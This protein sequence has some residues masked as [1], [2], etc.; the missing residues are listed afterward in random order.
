LNRTHLFYII[1]AIAIVG[2]LIAIGYSLSQVQ[3]NQPVPINNTKP[4]PVPIVC[5][6][7]TYLHNGTCVAEP[8][9]ICDQG[10]MF[11]TTSELCEPVPTIPPEEP[12]QPLDLI[13]VGDIH[14]SKG[15]EVGA[16]IQA[17]NPD[18]IA[19]LGDLCYTDN[20]D[21]IEEFYGQN[22]SRI[23]CVIGN[24]EKPIIKI[25]LELCG[26][27]YHIKQFNNVLLFG[28]NTETPLTTETKL[29]TALL[30]NSTFMKDIKTVFIFTHKGVATP[31]QSHHPASEDSDVPKF[32]QAVIKDAPKN[33]TL[34]FVNGHNH[35]RSEGKI[36]TNYFIQSGGGGRSTSGYECGINAQFYYCEQDYGFVKFRLMPTGDVTWHFYNA[37][38][39]EVR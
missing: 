1:A 17:Q 36:G 7:G 10:E 31:P 25:A 9:P 20:I 37:K 12:A 3:T 16:S 26:N 15:K 14:G 27:D 13:A 33:V 35:V 21:C 32:G 19:L 23:F 18:I 30:K 2:L 29:V 5:G 8:I 6:N 34:I 28:I 24:H 22:Q 11:N 39:Q 38:G 4:E